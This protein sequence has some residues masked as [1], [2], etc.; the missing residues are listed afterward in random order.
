M[1][2]LPRDFDESDIPELHFVQFLFERQW[3]QLHSST[4][5]FAVANMVFKSA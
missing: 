3:F 5:R 1:T 4:N 2:L